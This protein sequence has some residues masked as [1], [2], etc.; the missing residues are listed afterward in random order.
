MG[1]S[2]ILDRRAVQM[3]RGAATGVARART[4]RSLIAGIAVAAMVFAIIG[5]GAHHCG[6]GEHGEHHYGH[7][8]AH[9]GLATTGHSSAVGGRHA[10]LLGES[11]ASHHPEQL[12]SAIRPHHPGTGAGAGAGV[13]IAITVI[14]VA[15]AASSSWTWAGRDPPRRPLYAMSGRSLLTRFCLARR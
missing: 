11:A 9:A 8:L 1:S 13:G 12:T 6:H 4:P 7:G 5:I 2:A 10:F 14:A 15:A 3:H